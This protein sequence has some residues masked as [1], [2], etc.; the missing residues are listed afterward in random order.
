MATEGLGQ[1]SVTAWIGGLKEGAG[2]DA[3]AAARE[4]WGRYFADLARIARGRLGASP[5]AAADEEDVAL[6]AFQ[7][8]CAGVAEGR[9]ERLGSRDDLWKLLVT[10]TL[11]KAID[12]LERQGR[13]KRGG[14]RVRDEADLIGSDTDAAGPLAQV[15]GREPG[16]DM[17]ALVAEQCEILLGKL[18]D[19]SLRRVALLRMEGYTSHEIAERFGCNRRTITRK[20]ELIRQSWLSEA[21]PHEAPADDDP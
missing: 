21:G 16:P 20:L 17:A 19:E 3:D 14:G 5:L 10:I 18:R 15:P 12:Q 9:F 1:G 4:L 6:S 2:H 7:S 13:R 8:L 11:R